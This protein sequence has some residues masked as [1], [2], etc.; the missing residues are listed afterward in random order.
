MTDRLALFFRFIH[1]GGFQQDPF[2]VMGGDV[3]DITVQD[4]AEG[5]DRVHIDTLIV[6]QA[7][8]Q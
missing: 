1:R 2:P 5:V 6:L 7:V 3:L 4:V 8:D